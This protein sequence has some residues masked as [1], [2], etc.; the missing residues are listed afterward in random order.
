MIRRYAEARAVVFTPQDEDL[1]YITLE[2]MLSGKPVIT[3]TDAGGPLE[4]ITQNREG[5]ITA[6]DAQALSQAFVRLS[7]DA[8]LAE[9][10]GSAGLARY[11][12][13]NIS[14]EHVV[15]TL[16]GQTAQAQPG[17]AQIAAL[18]VR[19]AATPAAAAVARVQAAVAPPS[20]PPL[21]FASITEVLEAYA[22]DT[23]PA[24]DGAGPAPVEPGLA[25]YLGT[26]WTRYQTTLHHV[27]GCAP[28]DILDVGV[29]P[30]LAFEAMVINALPDVKMSGVWEGPNPYAQ[31][32]KSL[33]PAY[34]DF[35]IEL[36]PANIERDVMPYGDA[37]FDMVLGMEIFEHLALDPHFFLKPPACCAP[38]AISS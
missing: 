2:A 11:Q 5:L 8:A 13:L 25:Q 6:P 12:G 23:L 4:F 22:F 31:S 7:E 36:R 26:H 24:E 3:T 20:P 18:E 28:R 21:P 16:T 37:E 30:P 17:P 32:V 38:V 29:F 15:E 33:N 10:M 9:T 27:V 19:A 14:W 1:G 34:P 35:D